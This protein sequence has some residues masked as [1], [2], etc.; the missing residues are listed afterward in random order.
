MLSAFV[1]DI[2][3]GDP[4]WLPHPVVAIGRLVTTL[5][6]PLRRLMP[7]T[8]KG[9]RMAGGIMVLSVLS[10][11]A[12]VTCFGLYLAN[13][14]H[15]TLGFALELFWCY[16]LLATGCLAQ[17]AMGVYR[18]LLGG[19]LED[20][21]RAVGRIV[22]R[23][24]N[25]L[26]AQGITKATVE[27]V[28]E[29]TCDGTVAPMLFLAIGG[30]PAGMLYKAIN[31]MDSM[32]GYRNDRYRHFGTVAARLDDAANWLPA[33]LSALLIIAS[34]ALLGQNAAN[35][36]VIWRRDRR[37]HK[38]PNS[39]HPESACAGALGVQLAGD[40]CYFGQLVHKPTIGDPL[41]TIEPRDIRRAN[42]LL[43]VSAILCLL[44]CCG[45]R[46]CTLLI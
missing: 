6:K 5:E 1:L 37:N 22:G 32:V 23:D 26:T 4:A 31:T 21:Q 20:A 11:T 40:A 28:A 38:S 13:M 12:A 46:L 45:I 42:R 44:L 36:L 15:P 27:T 7:K 35:A 30:V 3:F 34:S 18:T 29:N 43:Y 33:R 17:E 16:Q 19:T 39:A 2:L 24:T 8:P 10:I 14:L 9:E 41:R 25:L